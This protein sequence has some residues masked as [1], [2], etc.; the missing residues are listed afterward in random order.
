MKILAVDTSGP[1][2]GVALLDED[3]LL[4][5]CELTHRRTHSEW[6]MPAVEQAL[7]QTQLSPAEVDLYAAVVGPGSFTGVRI[8]VTTVKTLAQATGKPCIGVHALETLVAGVGAFDG[9]ICPILDARAG[10][11]YGA[12]FA[13]GLPPQRLLEDVA[14]KLPEFLSQACAL[15]KPLLFAGD[16]VPVFRE[17][18]AEALGDRAAFAPPHLCGLRAGAAAT[19]A[20]C[21]AEQAVDYAT[22][23][24]LYLR[25]PQAERERAAKLA[26]QAVVEEASHG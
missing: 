7:A 2:V 14:C 13:P 5:E 16:G 11:V 8:G 24:P 6:L 20:R 21:R 15:N 25:A 22:L 1:S 10:Q 23:M 4:F 12:A 26:A 19:L 18:I 3:R 17:R 9:A